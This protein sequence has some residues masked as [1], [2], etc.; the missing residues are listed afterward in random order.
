VGSGTAA[1][2]PPSTEGV[3]VVEVLEERLDPLKLLEALEALS[4]LHPI[5]PKSIMA[6]HKIIKNNLT[7]FIFLNLLIIIPL[8]NISLSDF[9]LL[10]RRCQDKK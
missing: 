8:K 10:Q 5:N 9:G 2:P 7:F 1:G 4:F 6:T 3:I